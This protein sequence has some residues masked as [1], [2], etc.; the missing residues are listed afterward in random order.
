MTQKIV[1]LTLSD[2]TM[3]RVHAPG[4]ED[5]GIFIR[6][7]PSLTALQRAFQAAQEA[8]MGVL[9]MPVDVPDSAI[10]GVYPLLRS[11]VDM[12]EEQFKALPSVFDSLAILQALSMFVPNRLAAGSVAPQTS[13][14]M[15]T[16]AAL[17]S[18]SNT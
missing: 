13:L 11:M 18:P 10:Q 12:T 15:K 9:G 2:G 8:S 14:D 4:P 17:S 16:E 3:L 1:E 7:L 5:L 6:S